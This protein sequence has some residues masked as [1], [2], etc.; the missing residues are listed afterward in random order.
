MTSHF[1]KISQTICTLSRTLQPSNFWLIQ[2]QH[3]KME[4]IKT[5]GAMGF[6]H[7]AVAR[8]MGN[9]IL[10]LAL[11][12]IGT[13]INTEGKN[14]GDKAAILFNPCCS[15]INA[16][17]SAPTESLILNP[18]NDIVVRDSK[19]KIVLSQIVKSGRYGVTGT[20]EVLFQTRKLP[21]FG[22]TT[23][24][25]D[26][27]KHG[28]ASTVSDLRISDSGWKMENDFV[29]VELDAVSGGIN[30]LFDR[31]RSIEMI[32]GNKRAFP[33][34]SGKPNQTLEAN[35]PEEYD[36]AKSRAEI[37]WVERGPVRAII[38]VVHSWPLMRFEHWIILQAG[39]PCVEVEIKVSAD[40]PPAMTKERVN[41]W[42]PPLHI[43]DGYWFSF[44]SAFKPIDVIRDYPFGVESCGK[45]AIDTLNF[46]DV[47]GQHGG[48][49]IVH[50]RNS[51][52]QAQRR[53]CLFQFGYKRLDWDFF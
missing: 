50:V 40:V 33:V 5:W 39:Q 6:R 45:D 43:T 44:A 38:K 46:L 3:W 41:G 48:L 20:T 35:S 24:Y 34:F 18:E 7:M 42:Q 11:Q 47:I 31:K 32:D 8:K 30:R 28:E 13:A 51:I 53:C 9:N 26:Q 23:Y 29:S 22:Y 4:S 10:N 19:G 21:S 14:H 1:A 36:S 2:V 49:L 37:S 15:E 27:A 25:L 12:S 52:F 16:I 17:V